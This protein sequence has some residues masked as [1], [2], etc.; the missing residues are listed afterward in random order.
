MCLQPDEG[1]HQWQF[2]RILS[3]AAQASR[4]AAKSAAEGDHPSLQRPA[5]RDFCAGCV[6]L[7]SLEGSMEGVTVALLFQVHSWQEP[8]SV[9]QH[10]VADIG[11][12]AVSVLQP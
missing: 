10:C 9:S 6:F 8:H 3:P 12:C 4:E 1:V 5:L 2:L 7:D 11:G